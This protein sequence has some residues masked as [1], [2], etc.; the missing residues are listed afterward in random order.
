MKKIENT[1]SKANKLVGEGV[2]EY[3]LWV[4]NDGKLY[5][6]FEENKI[7]TPKAGTLSELLYPV[8]EYAHLRGL[9]DAIPAPQGWDINSKSFEIGEDNNNSAFLKAV[10]R[11]L[12]P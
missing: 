1:T 2:I 8:S 12:L 3:C 10:L 11:H 6:Q 9:N 7:N 5:V 4:D